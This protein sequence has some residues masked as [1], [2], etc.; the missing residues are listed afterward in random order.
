M[1]TGHGMT[2]LTQSR[3]RCS[4][5]KQG[6][7]VETILL[8]SA[9]EKR[10]KKNGDPYYSLT[11]ADA[12]GTVQGVMWDNHD[13]LVAELL[14]VGDFVRVEAFAADYNGALQLTVRRLD[15]VP[16]ADVEMADFLAVSPRSRPEMEAEL[17]ALIAT[18]EN[19]DCRRLLDRLLG[20]AKLR[21][22]YCTAPAAAKVHQAYI[23]GLLE[24]T[25]N[26]VRTALFLGENYKPYDRDVLVT[27]GLLHDIGKIREYNWRRLIVYTDEGRLMGHISIG[28]AMIDGT[29]RALAREEGGFSPQVHQHILHCVLSHHG[30]LEYGSP[31]VPKTKE[32]LMLHYADYTDAYL[33][34]YCDA[35]VA[36][37]NKNQGWTPYNKMFEAYLYAGPPAT[38]PG[39]DVG[40]PATVP[41]AGSE[42]PRWGGQQE[43]GNLDG[44]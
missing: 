43:A 6:E 29:M 20:H 30:K 23:S 38:A 44:G 26:V 8:L 11:F 17:D 39:S 18:V 15:R 42:D 33:A 2:S 10:S 21:E 19:Q 28:A 37:Q 31:V 7:A 36:A 3:T 40:G 22:L 14:K 27:A 9:A 12:S 4:D 41:Q 32:A 34:S 25:L 13:A 5:I 16:D 24:H 35:I 1:V